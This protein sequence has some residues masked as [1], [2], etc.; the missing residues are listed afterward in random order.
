MMTPSPVVWNVPFAM[1]PTAFATS[2][3]APLM[4]RNAPKDHRSTR[5]RE[6]SSLRRLGRLCL[7]LT[8]EQYLLRD[9]AVTHPSGTPRA[10]LP[11][12][13][14]RRPAR[15]M[16]SAGGSS[17]V[18]IHSGSVSIRAAESPAT[19]AITPSTVAIPWAT[20]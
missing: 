15:G 3:M 11:H 10:P 17:R 16:R 13:P 4:A 6:N 20:A 14:R 2:P 19:I 18:K 8:G 5:L 9:E 1:R 7:L 12:R